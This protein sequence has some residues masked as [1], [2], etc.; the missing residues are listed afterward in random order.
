[1]RVYIYSSMLVMYDVTILTSINSKQVSIKIIIIIIS[2]R[3]KL[4][5][6]TRSFL[7]KEAA[8]NDSASICIYIYVYL[9]AIKHCAMFIVKLKMYVRIDILRTRA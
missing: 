3:L 2:R 5:L 1:M 9:R 6:L 4:N 7:L 8:L